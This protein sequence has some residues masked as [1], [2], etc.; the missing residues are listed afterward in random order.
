MR[1]II[2]GIGLVLV[3]GVPGATQTPASGEDPP[4]PAEIRITVPVVAAGARLEPET[5]HIRVTGERPTSPAGTAI[6]AQRWAEIVLGGRVLARE[7]AERL[8]LDQVHPFGSTGRAP[9]REVRVELLRGG[10]F[11]PVSI[12]GDEARYVLH[13]AV[14][15]GDR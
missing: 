1:L 10:E 7:V 5:Y 14:V 12:S 9:P 6:E 8:P 13:L 3:W 2:A 15:C 11:P 4:A